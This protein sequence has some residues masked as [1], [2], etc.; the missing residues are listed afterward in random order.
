MLQCFDQQPASLA[1]Q[2]IENLPGL[3]S[4]QPDHDFA[5]R[6][7]GIVVGNFTQTGRRLFVRCMRGG[8]GRLD[9][10]AHGRAI[11]TQAHMRFADIAGT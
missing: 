8:Q 3:P 4:Q 2:P 1:A 9:D 5:V 11:L 10:G 7:R 6:E